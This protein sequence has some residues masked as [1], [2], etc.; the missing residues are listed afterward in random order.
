MWAFRPSHRRRSRR[1][2]N[3]PGKKR[4]VAARRKCKRLTLSH[5]LRQSAKSADESCAGVPSTLASSATVPCR[6]CSRQSL[7]ASAFFVSIVSFVVKTLG[8]TAR[9]AA[10]PPHVV[11]LSRCYVANRPFPSSLN[12]LVPNNSLSSRSHP[13]PTFPQLPQLSARISKPPHTR[14]ILLILFP[15]RSPT[16]RIMGPSRRPLSIFPRRRAGLSSFGAHLRRLLA[17][18]CDALLGRRMRAE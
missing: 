7:T 3:R 10:C 15:P 6:L 4:S 18:R 2:S 9:A 8:T 11:T 12:H 1:R 13:L 17:Q 16:H 14:L 5:N